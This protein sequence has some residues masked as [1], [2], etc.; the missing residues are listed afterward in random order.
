[1]RSRLLLPKHDYLNQIICLIDSCSET[2]AEA[3][4]EEN[5]PAMHEEVRSDSPKPEPA[6][7]VQFV[8]IFHDV[9]ATFALM[10][11]IFVD[12]L[13]FFADFR[14]SFRKLRPGRMELRKHQMTVE[15]L[16]PTLC[17]LIYR[18]EYQLQLLRVV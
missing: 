11:M 16:L 1:M 12:S 7:N 2:L 10:S 14:K 4:L 5:A 9:L 8:S 13:L 15:Q 3:E 18:L 17:S 6:S